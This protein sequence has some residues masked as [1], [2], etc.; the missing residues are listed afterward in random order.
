VF[1]P[2]GVAETADLVRNVF[3]GDS[4]GTDHLILRTFPTFAAP[5]GE[6]AVTQQVNERTLSDGVLGPGYNQ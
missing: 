5:F 4:P 2:S 6:P 3:R 1:D